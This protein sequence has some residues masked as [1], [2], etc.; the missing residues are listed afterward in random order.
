MLD[1]QKCVDTWRGW[2][3]GLSF[4]SSALSS[5]ASS[6]STT[7][8]SRSA[9]TPP[10]HQ[11][12]PREQWSW[13][14]PIYLGPGRATGL[15]NYVGSGRCIGEVFYQKNSNNGFL[16]AISGR[17]R[18]PRLI[19][20]LSTCSFLATSLTRASGALPRS[21][22][23]MSKG[24][25]TRISRQR[26]LKLHFFIF[27]FHSLFPSGKDTRIHVVPGNHDM[28]FH[29]ALS[30]YLDKRFKSAF[31]TKAVQL[32]V[33]NWIDIFQSFTGTFLTRLSTKFHLCW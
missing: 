8:S 3:A 30:P 20:V 33:S 13:Q 9:L 16:L 28:G 22:S 2:G 31:N 24:A 1:F 4:S 18:Q 10:P 11:Q 14:T 12:G 32:K 26:E 25:C 17:S 29:Y 27:R 7:S 21:L 15:T 19:S 23:I 6:W 5:T